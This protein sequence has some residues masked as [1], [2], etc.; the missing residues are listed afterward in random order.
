MKKRGH[1]AKDCWFEKK[2]WRCYN[3][4]EYDHKRRE[5]LKS[6]QFSL[7]NFNL[8]TNRIKRNYGTDQIETLPK[9]QVKA[10]DCSETKE[11]GSQP[12]SV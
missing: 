12:G 4:G 1:V 6:K 8:Q 3:F 7:G 11:I 2:H 10:S 5:C 9:S